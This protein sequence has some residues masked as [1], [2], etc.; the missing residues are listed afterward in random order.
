MTKISVFN[1]N[2]SRIWFRKELHE[3]L[4][5]E[6]TKDIADAKTELA[7]ASKAGRG[8]HGPAWQIGR[9]CLAPWKVMT[10]CRES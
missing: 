2:W 10:T 1:S 9:R 3:A 8:L 6:S 7:N 4:D 5:V